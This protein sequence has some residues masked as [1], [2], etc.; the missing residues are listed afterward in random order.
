MLEPNCNRIPLGTQE[1]KLGTLTSRIHARN[2]FRNILRVWHER[3]R[4]SSGCVL[5]SSKSR[6][7]LTRQG[8]VGNDIESGTAGPIQL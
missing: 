4:G 7:G 2:S 5:A 8:L 6:Q 1:G 3:A